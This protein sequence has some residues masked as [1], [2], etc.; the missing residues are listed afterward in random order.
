[1]W[2]VSTYNVS[3]ENALKTNGVVDHTWKAE[4][5]GSR[6]QDKSHLLS[7]VS[8]TKRYQRKIFLNEHQCS[9]ANNR[10]N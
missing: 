5:G 6:C 10:K 2:K 3:V 8:T 9:T 1:M 7:I 4:A